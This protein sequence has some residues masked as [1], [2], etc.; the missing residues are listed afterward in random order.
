MFCGGAHK[1]EARNSRCAFTPTAPV[2]RPL[3]L[4]CCLRLGRGG[5]INIYVYIYLIYKSREG[6]CTRTY[7]FDV[8]ARQLELAKPRWL[9]GLCLLW[10]NRWQLAA[11]LLFWR[12]QEVSYLP[13]IYSFIHIFSKVEEIQRKSLRTCALRCSAVCKITA[14][15]SSVFLCYFYFSGPPL[16]LQQCMIHALMSAL[17]ALANE[18]C[19]R[20][21]YY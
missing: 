20:V 17:G 7:V 2:T 13:I 14:A 12:R 16:C 10:V 1:Q 5:I 21:I 15:S 11:V 8:S 18:R 6:T 9:A 4:R 3:S 19:C